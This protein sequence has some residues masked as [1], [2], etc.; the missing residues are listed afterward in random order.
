MKNLIFPLEDYDQAT[1]TLEAIQD[2]LNLMFLPDE[3]SNSSPVPGA[4]AISIL[5]DSL[6][7][8]L[9]SLDT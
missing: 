2:V 3:C 8:I 4:C 7:G 1:L 5:L 6:R 9:V